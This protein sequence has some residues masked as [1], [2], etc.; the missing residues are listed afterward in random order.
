MVFDHG[1]VFLEHIDVRDESSMFFPDPDLV[2]MVL[3][4]YSGLLNGAAKA[5]APLVFF[6]AP[7]SFKYPTAEQ[8]MVYNELILEIAEF[9]N[10]V[11]VIDSASNVEE[12]SVRY[13]RYDGLHFTPEGQVNFVV[14]QIAPHFVSD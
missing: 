11:Y 7:Y 6:T 14:D 8:A 4:S 12:N 3:E 13:P 10:H 9:N 5:D 1:A 2:E